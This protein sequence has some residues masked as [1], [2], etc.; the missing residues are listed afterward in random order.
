MT[1]QDM[2]INNIWNTYI[3]ETGDG[4]GHFGIM[5][6]YQFFFYIKGIYKDS[7]ANNLQKLNKRLRYP[8]DNAEV[9]KKAS[10]HLLEGIAAGSS[11]LKDD[12]NAALGIQKRG[13]KK[14]S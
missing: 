4:N 14:A 1:E 13:R 9:Y 11:T 5:K 6:L 3:D 2:A 12:V 10:R 8:V 7:E